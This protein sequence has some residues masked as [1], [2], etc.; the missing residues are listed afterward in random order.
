[1]IA[2]LLAQDPP[3]NFVAPTMVE[4]TLGHPSQ[5]QETIPGLQQNFS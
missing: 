5:N 2:P 1:M 3:C 4:F